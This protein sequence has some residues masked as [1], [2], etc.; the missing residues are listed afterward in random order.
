MTEE[1]RRRADDVRRALGEFLDRLAKAVAAG[2]ARSGQVGRSS[3]RPRGPRADR[4]RKSRWHPRP[5]SF[6]SGSS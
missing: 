5:P 4:P 1:D 3:P 6:S 2:L